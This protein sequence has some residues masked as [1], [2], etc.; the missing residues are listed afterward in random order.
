[1]GEGRDTPTPAAGSP[2]LP[3]DQNLDPVSDSHGQAA[4]PG[5]PPLQEGDRS[6]LGAASISLNY[7]SSR[8]PILQGESFGGQLL[9][10]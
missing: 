2:L 10:G 5:Q 7:V 3:S 9:K 1:M 4:F 6:F 8:G